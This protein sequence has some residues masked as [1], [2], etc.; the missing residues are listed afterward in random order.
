M[1][2][3]MLFS[4]KDSGTRRIRLVLVHSKHNLL[5]YNVTVV[6][7]VRSQR[8][9]RDRISWPPLALPVRPSIHPFPLPPLF[10]CPVMWSDVLRVFPN[11]SSTLTWLEEQHSGPYASNKTTFQCLCIWSGD[12][13]SDCQR[14]SL[15]SY[16]A[17]PRSPSAIAH[18]Q[19]NPCPCSLG[20]VLDLVFRWDLSHSSCCAPVPEQKY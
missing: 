19:S 9:S 14:L 2:V 5:V 17:H 16:F 12:H 7:T 11:D 18:V 6:E 15:V 13:V 10:S 4:C 8:R 1:C 20:P 3:H